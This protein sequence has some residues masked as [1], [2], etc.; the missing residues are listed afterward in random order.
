MKALYVLGN[1]SLYNDQEIKYSIRS[2]ERHADGITSIVIIGEKP[3]F[4]NYD[5]VEHYQFFETGN[6]EYRI[7]SK[8]LFACKNKIVEGEFLFMNDDFFFTAPF[9][10]ASYP[11]FQRGPLLIGNPKS[12]YQQHLQLT[13]DYL[14]SKGKHALHFDVHTPIVY[15]SEKFMALQDCW[16]YS[17]KSIGL[18]VKS[19]YCNMHNLIGPIYTDVKLKSLNCVEDYQKL[20][21]SNCF[22]INDA[23]WN[24]DRA[25]SNG[26]EQ[27][28][29]DSYPNKSTFEL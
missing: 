1:G 23:P 26:V 5:K 10:A 19:T 16:D 25:W 15:N 8:I 11:Y 21:S 20:K 29:K 12:A 4:L 17:A 7:A 24:Q 18:V 3:S 22:S 27:Y 6:K 9:Q 2:L 28:L 14:F 13:R